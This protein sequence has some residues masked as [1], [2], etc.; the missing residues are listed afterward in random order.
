MSIVIDQAEVK[1]AIAANV[2]RL[3]AA[4]GWSQDE[5]AQRAGMHRVQINRIENAHAEPKASAVFSLA[6][7]FGVS[8]DV[9]RVVC[10][11]S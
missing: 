8:A 1:S 7:A 3:R 10:G 9:L 11:N 6:D 2:V 5:L 4:R